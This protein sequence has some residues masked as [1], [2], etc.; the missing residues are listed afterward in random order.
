M[1]EPTRRDW[2]ALITALALAA[3]AS[4]AGDA[5]QP[6]VPASLEWAI[7]ASNLDHTLR[8][9]CLNGGFEHV[10]SRVFFQWLVPDRESETGARLV[11]SRLVKEIGM[12]SAGPP[13]ITAAGIGFRV[14]I[15][16]ARTYE[17]GEEEFIF[18]TGGP[19]QYRLVKQ[20]G[21]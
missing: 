2:L 6:D 5:E 3:P 20:R 8:V 14:V 13:Q 12:V 15:S 18:L 11:S 21:L 16:A 4:R 9:V 10:S 19:G 7:S 17:E 1:A